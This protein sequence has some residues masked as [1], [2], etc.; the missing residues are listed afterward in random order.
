MSSYIDEIPVPGNLSELDDISE[1]LGNQS[2][3]LEGAFDA[4][5]E[6]ERGRTPDHEPAI[7]QIELDDDMS[8]DEPSELDFDME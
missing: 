8:R 6:I 7:D 2:S 1:N 4:I 3:L 5:T